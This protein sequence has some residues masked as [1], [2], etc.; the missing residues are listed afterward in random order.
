MSA[1]EKEMAPKLN[2]EQEG[3]QKGRLLFV[4]CGT[5]LVKLLQAPPQGT[6][7]PSPFELVEAGVS[8]R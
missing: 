8:G 4:A 6:P 7:A 3:S 1:P 2:G 5:G